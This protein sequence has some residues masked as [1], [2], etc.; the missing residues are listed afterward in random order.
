VTANA[1]KF[2]I[3]VTALFVT[4]PSL[5]TLLGFGPMGYHDGAALVVRLV[6][7]F[8]AT[9]LLALVVGLAMYLYYVNVIAPAPRRVERV[10]VRS[11]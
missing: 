4:G 1:R 7:M 11:S 8:L 9:S 6:A 3:A 2:I 5:G 10:T